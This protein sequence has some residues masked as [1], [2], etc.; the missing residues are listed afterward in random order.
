MI[1]QIKLLI[2]SNELPDVGNPD[3]PAEGSE[4]DV[5]HIVHVLFDLLDLRVAGAYRVLDRLHL[6]LQH[7]YCGVS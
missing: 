3:V 5:L 7:T 1:L 4:H 2:G 6:R